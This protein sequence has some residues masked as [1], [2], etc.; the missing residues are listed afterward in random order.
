MFPIGALPS[1]GQD[2]SFVNV[3]VT[4]CRRQASLGCSRECEYE[5][6]QAVFAFPTSVPLVH[7]S[8][9]FDL[10]QNNNSCYSRIITF[11][12]TGCDPTNRASTRKDIK[13]GSKSVRIQQSST[14]RTVF[15]LLHPRTM[16]TS[17]NTVVCLYHHGSLLLMTSILVLGVWWECLDSSSC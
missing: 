2:P 16:P 3:T 10:E 12:V 11:C 15:L 6:K 7:V 9:L 4:L 14:N 13:T 5:I 8:T 1:A 17:A